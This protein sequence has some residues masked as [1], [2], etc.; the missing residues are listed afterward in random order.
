[1][2]AVSGVVDG[3]ILAAHAVVQ[4]RES[5]QFNRNIADHG[6]PKWAS[7]D[8]HVANMKAQEQ[9]R[10]QL[11]SVADWLT[12]LQGDLADVRMETISYRG[13]ASR[14]RLH[15]RAAPVPV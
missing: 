1:M 5:S 9:L 2:A 4:T 15:G 7:A 13:T 14:E 12:A 10:Q 3:V 11:E 8:G 6:I